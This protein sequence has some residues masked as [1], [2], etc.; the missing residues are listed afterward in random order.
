ML[1]QKLMTLSNKIESSA[2]IPRQRYL[3]KDW[4][5]KYYFL[6]FQKKSAKEDEN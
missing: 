4:I 1:L 6:K 5:T 2:A 3:M